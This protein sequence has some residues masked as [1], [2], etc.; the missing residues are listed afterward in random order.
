[1]DVPGTVLPRTNTDSHGAGMVAANIHGA[2]MVA[3]RII[4]TDKHGLTRE[5]NF[6]DGGLLEKGLWMGA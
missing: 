5:E 1:M 6:H 2:G 3:G 4:A